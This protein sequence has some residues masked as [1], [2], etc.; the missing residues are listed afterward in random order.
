MEADNTEKKFYLVLKF[1]YNY[2]LSLLTANS[3]LFNYC[4]CLAEINLTP[5]LDW[6]LESSDTDSHCGKLSKVDWLLLTIQS[7]VQEKNT[8][9]SN[10]HNNFINFTV[11]LHFPSVASLC[12]SFFV[13]GLS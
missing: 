6:T 1:Y 12:K 5:W 9:I 11:K 13:L 10:R 8:R 2:I 3:L 4:L 7:L